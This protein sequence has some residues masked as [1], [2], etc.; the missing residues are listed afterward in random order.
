MI[1]AAAKNSEV[2]ESTAA[3]PVLLSELR[4]GDTAILHGFHLDRR[5]AALLEAIGLTLGCELRVCKAG[6]PAIVQAR[7]TRVA[8]AAA[9]AR[10]LHVVPRALIA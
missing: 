6:E 10:G 4:P 8:L 1:R 5:E 9:V 2:R 7:S 3:V